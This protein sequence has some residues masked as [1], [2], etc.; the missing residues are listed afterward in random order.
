MAKYWKITDTLVR[1]D[2]LDEEV[3]GIVTDQDTTGRWQ[4]YLD[5]IAEGNIAEQWTQL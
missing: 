4:K 5:W 2:D 1:F 3:A